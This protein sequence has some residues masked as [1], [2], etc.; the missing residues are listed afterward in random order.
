MQLAREREC[1]KSTSFIRNLLSTCLFCIGALPLFKKLGWR[2][3]RSRVRLTLR[4]CD[5]LRKP[6]SG[7]K[8]LGDVMYK[9]I[10]STQLYALLVQKGGNALQ[11][12]RFCFICSFGLKKPIYLLD[13][14]KIMPP[15]LDKRTMHA[16]VRVISK[17][18]A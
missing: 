16:L 18:S 2:Y 7:S 11:R 8:G 6:R 5:L 10:Y 9:N 13:F 3:V 17:N 1:S 15:L 12:V 4:G 14:E